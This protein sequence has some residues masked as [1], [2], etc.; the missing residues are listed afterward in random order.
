ML[1]HLVLPIARHLSVCW[2]L[3]AGR[4]DSTNASFASA[5]PDEQKQQGVYVN[6]SVRIGNR[7]SSKTCAFLRQTERSGIGNPAK[8]GF[9]PSKPKIFFWFCGFVFFVGFVGFR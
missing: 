5:S 9:S 1:Q 3:V 8:L 2:S 4:L 6:F 7:E